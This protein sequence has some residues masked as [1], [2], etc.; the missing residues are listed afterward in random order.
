MLQTVRHGGHWN[1]DWMPSL[2]LPK[3]EEEKK[4]AAKKYGLIPADYKTYP[5]DGTGYG[6][7]PK[8]DIVSGESRDPHA[9]WDMPELKRNF[10]EPFH[11]EADLY[12][13]DRVDYNR[14]YQFSKAWHHYS[15]FGVVAFL[16]VLF[17]TGE[18]VKI[19]DVQQM[20]RHVPYDGKK[21]YSFETQPLD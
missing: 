11:V 10:G 9:L 6:D 3:T 14:K 18:Q 17:W 21:H 5:D 20:P 1:A 2:K 12:T 15:F 4:A 13:E 19:V 8:I 7:Y 16:A